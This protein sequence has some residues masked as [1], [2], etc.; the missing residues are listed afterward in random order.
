MLNHADPFL[1]HSPHPYA[2]QETSSTST[3]DKETSTGKDPVTTPGDEAFATNSGE[4]ES[5]TYRGTKATATPLAISFSFFSGTRWAG[6]LT[7]GGITRWQT[8]R[9]EFKLR[10]IDIKCL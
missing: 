1:E 7:Q 5:P 6:P 9:V 8:R 4:K 2:I 3:S 10:E